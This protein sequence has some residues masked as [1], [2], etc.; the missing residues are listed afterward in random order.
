MDKTRKSC[1]YALLG[2]IIWG[3]AFV[4]QKQNTVGTVTFFMLRHLIAFLMLIPVVWLFTK[5][6]KHLFTADQD[7]GSTKELWLGGLICGLFMTAAGLC[8]QWGLDLGSTAGKGSFITSFYMVLVPVG[9][10]L[11]LNQRV[12]LSM[13]GCLLLAML[14]LYL[15][16]LKPGER[17][18]L[19][20]LYLLA[21]AILYTGHILAVDRFSHRV[22]PVKL[23]CLQMLFGALL[24]AVP[25]LVFETL[26]WT[27]LKSS[28][29]PMLY[30]GIFSSGVGFSL[31]VLAQSGADN[32]PLVTLFMS[33]ESVFGALFGA[34]I[35]KERLSFREIAGCILMFAAV[36][37]S[38]VFLGRKGKS[39]ARL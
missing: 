6:P 25:A 20:D 36:A 19:P 12:R 29:I 21:C 38:Q 28:L 27:G 2:A 7:E 3:F 33:M 37:F 16:C 4:M 24:T 1:I 18:E 9:A 15:L 5:D 39:N 11:L 35:L 13:W 10:V 26:T 34:L 17:F 8:Q 32:A 30:L 23:A 31:Q 22:N 14:G